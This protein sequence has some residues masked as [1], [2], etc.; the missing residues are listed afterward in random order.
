MSK[1]QAHNGKTTDKLM[2][3]NKKRQLENE[4]FLKLFRM[5]PKVAATTVKIIKMPL[6]ERYELIEKLELEKE[7]KVFNDLSS[8]ET[9]SIKSE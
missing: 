4:T 2:S 6:N 8:Y 1:K 5:L 9:S 3:S 7:E